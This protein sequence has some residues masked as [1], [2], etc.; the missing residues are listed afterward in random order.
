MPVSDEAPGRPDGRQLRSSRTREAVA[1]AMLALVEGGNPW[2]T[3]REV[4][5]QAGVSERAVFRHFQDLEALFHAVADL[6]LAKVGA[7]A[8]APAPPDAPAAERLDRFIARW[9]TI[10][11]LI[12]PVRRA[13]LLRAPFSEEVRG[14]HAWMRRLRAAEMSAALD[15]AGARLNAE[16]LAALTGV[17]SWSFWEQLRAHQ[18]LSKSRAAATVRR[19]VEGL[20]VSADSSRRS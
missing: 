18:R 1:V 20:L 3:S 8:P 5:A 6:Q 17:M 16:D 13:S 14:R 4:A 15:G 12:T 19:A 2:P 11:E 9:C 7:R 10:H